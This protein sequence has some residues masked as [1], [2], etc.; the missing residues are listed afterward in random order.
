[1]KG[2]DVSKLQEFLRDNTAYTGKI[3]GIFGQLTETAVKRWQKEKGITATGTVG[4]L[5]RAAMRCSAQKSQTSNSSQKTE[6]ATGNSSSRILSRGAKGSDVIELQRFL[7]QQGYLAAGND[8]GF[9][10]ALTEMALQKWQSNHGLVSHGSPK[11]TGYGAVGPD[12]KTAIAAE[13]AKGG[14]SSSNHSFSGSL[15]PYTQSE[16]AALIRKSIMP[17]VVQIR[18]SDSDGGKESAIG[19]GVYSLTP[20]THRPVVATNAH[21][22]LGSDGQFHGCNIY[23]PLAS[24]GMFSFYDSAYSAGEATLFHNVKSNIAGEI[25]NGIDYAVLTLTG[26]GVDAQGLSYPFPP[27]QEDALQAMTKLCR[28]IDNINIGD[29]IY[30]IGYPGIGGSSLTLSQGVIS[31]FLGLFNEMIKVSANTVPG[32]SGGLAIGQDD[33]CEYGIPTRAITD[34]RAGGNIGFLLSSG[35]INTFVENMTGNLTYSPPD[36]SS[37]P[38]TYLTRTHTFPDFSMCYPVLWNVSQKAPDVE[39]TLAT[40]F[41]SPSEGALDD[42]TENISVA[43]KPNSTQDDLTETVAYF[44][45]FSQGLISSESTITLGG[46]VQAYHVAFIDSSSGMEIFKGRV[47]FLENGHLYVIRIDADSNGF[48]VDKYSKIFNQ[49][50]TSIKFNVLSQTGQVPQ[51]A[52]AL[53]AFENFLKALQYGLKTRSL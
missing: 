12:T 20:D 51:T 37:D 23:F 49:M 31:G 40:F 33:L 2:D 52:N 18:C 1:M 27:K 16:A 42:F 46:R 43:V 36:I 3:G 13:R 10:G 21:V 9:F 14:T 15:Q 39:G 25:V 38:N 19:S 28:K 34:A 44:K 47:I 5:T 50:L 53:N 17:S 30:V 7:I 4:P 6:I 48:N 35:F 24:N 8:S 26:P 45:I 11:T 32:N 29:P 41:S 22:V